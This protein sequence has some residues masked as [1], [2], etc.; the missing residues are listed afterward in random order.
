[1][2]GPVTIDAPRLP[3]LE[4]DAHKGDAGRLLLLVGSDAMPGAGV[5]AAAAA[6]RGGVGLVSVAST[7]RRLLDAL[8]AAVPEALAIELGT[9]LEARTRLARAIA[10]G[11]F[12]ACAA[13]PGLGRGAGVRALVDLLL[14][15]DAGPILL[16]ADALNLFAGNPEGLS[17]AGAPLALTPHPGEAA[18]LLDREIGRSAPE[19]IAVA[20]ELA[21]RSRAA[22]LLKGASSV[23]ADGERCAVNPTGCAALAKGGSGDVLTG[24]AAAYA[25]RGDVGTT[26]FDVLCAAAWVHG[27]AGECAARDHGERAALPRHVIERLGEVQSALESSTGG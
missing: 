14:A 8:P 22:V 1:V 26:A 10:E 3:R 2:T 27:R 5:L 13:G 9:G 4:P 6:L 24:L 25:A 23:V 18:R 11:R 16:D 7:S 19:R 21:Q 15:G 17:Y 12:D 20:T